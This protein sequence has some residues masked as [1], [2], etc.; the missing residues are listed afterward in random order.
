MKTIP[1]LLGAVNGVNLTKLLNPVSHAGKVDLT[2][3]HCWLPPFIESGI[4]VTAQKSSLGFR[5]K[6]YLAVP[7]QI[8]I[9]N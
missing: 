3:D 2:G 8:A 4:I 9:P 5:N 6:A 1:S 7:F